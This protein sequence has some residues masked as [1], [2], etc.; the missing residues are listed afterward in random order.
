MIM[1]GISQKKE[2]RKKA[3]RLYVSLQIQYSHTHIYVHYTHIYIYIY[4]IVI[5][6]SLYSIATEGRAL[7]YQLNRIIL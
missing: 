6:W 5:I 1:R 2:N 3:K 4:L 7:T